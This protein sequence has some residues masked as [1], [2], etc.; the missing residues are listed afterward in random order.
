MELAKQEIA[1]IL[2]GLRQLQYAINQDEVARGVDEILLDGEV[3]DPTD[4]EID[5]LCE[6]IN[7]EGS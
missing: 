1:L 7:A 2:A 4:E 5:D 3:D 6:R